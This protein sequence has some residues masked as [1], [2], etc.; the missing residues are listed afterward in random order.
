MDNV[1]MVYILLVLSTLVVL[2]FLLLVAG[3]RRKKQIHY[4]VLSITVSILIANI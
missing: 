2:Y 3:R 1:D 4:A